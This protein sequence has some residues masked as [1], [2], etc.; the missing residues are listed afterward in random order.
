[1][2]RVAEQRKISKKFNIFYTLI[3]FIASEAILLQL[4]FMG[5]V[6]DPIGEFLFAVLL[7]SF[8]FSYIYSLGLMKGSAEGYGYSRITRIK[9]ILFYATAL[10]ATTISWYIFAL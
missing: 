7:V 6:G 5:M 9:A 10:I 4:L 8:A 1:M 2:L 3:S